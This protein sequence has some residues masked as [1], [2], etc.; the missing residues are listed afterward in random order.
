MREVPAR[1][2]PWAKAK[3]A[4]TFKGGGQGCAGPRAPSLP[5]GVH[6]AGLPLPL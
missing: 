1:P 4:A 3:A 6:G 2:A 5:L